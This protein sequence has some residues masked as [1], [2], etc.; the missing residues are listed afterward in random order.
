MTICLDKAYQIKSLK[1]PIQSIYS[2]KVPSKTKQTATK[3]AVSNNSLDFLNPNLKNGFNIHQKNADH[4]QFDIYS[5]EKDDSFSYQ[6]SGKFVSIVDFDYVNMDEL[7]KSQLNEIEANASVSQLI[8]EDV[9]YFFNC[10][11]LLNEESLLLASENGKIYHLVLNNQEQKYHTYNFD[12]KF[13]QD[14]L[15]LYKSGRKLLVDMCVDKM[16]NLLLLNRSMLNTDCKRSVSDYSVE[17]F[18]L[19]TANNSTRLVYKQT[20]F[21]LRNEDRISQKRFV[22]ILLI[23]FNILWMLYLK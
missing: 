9:K 10:F 2:P 7:N 4:A 5:S 21:V 3:P 22:L 6:C 14:D 15:E 19:F 11:V 23:C 13:K 18:S 20:L 8:F 17:V 1:M 16:G 12:V